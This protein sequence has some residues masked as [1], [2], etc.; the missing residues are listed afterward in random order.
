MRSKRVC[1]LICAIS[2]LLAVI[3]PG[4]LAQ[5]AGTGQVVGTVTDPSGAAVVGATVTLT[6]AAT[7]TSRTG[8]TRRSVII[9]N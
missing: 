4:L 2:M 5:M 7:N 6:D 1:L 9:R 8:T 3:P